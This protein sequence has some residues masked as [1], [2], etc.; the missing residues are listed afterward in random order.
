MPQELLDILAD[1]RAGR[2]NAA[3]DR[4]QR[5]DSLL[6]AWLHGIVHLQEGDLED[7]ENWYERGA[8]RFRS[9]GLLEEEMAAFEA[10]VREA[11]QH[12]PV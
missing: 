5:Q 3:H 10:A 2:W 11:Q 1:L 9:R 7:A 12:P 6:A 4:V 8:R